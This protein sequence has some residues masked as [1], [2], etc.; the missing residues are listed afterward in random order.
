MTLL[1]LKEPTETDLALKELFWRRGFNNAS[2][3]DVVKATGMNRYALYGAYGGKR[4]LFLAALDTYYHER[5]SVFLRSLNDPNAPP[6]DA[7]RR[8]F[9]FAISEMAERGAGCLL[10]NVATDVA[11]HDDVVA[12]RIEIYLEEI[13]LAHIEALSRAEAAGELNPNVTP[14]DGAA[15][16]MAVKIGLGVHAQRGASSADMLSTL[17]ATMRALKNVSAQ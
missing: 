12:E 3:E 11:P 10:C 8:V 6:L 1:P 2:I 13:R 14:A 4:D 16:L 5:K 9:E 15:L 17:E 7:I